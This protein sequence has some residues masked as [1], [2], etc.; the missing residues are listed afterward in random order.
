MKKNT[1]GILLGGVLGIV[2]VLGAIW[3]IRFLQTARTYSDAEQLISAGQYQE[4]L[5]DLKAIESNH[6]LDTEALIILCQAHLKYEDGEG[7]SAYTALKNTIFQHQSQEQMAEINA[8]M[9]ILKAEYDTYQQEQAQ[10]EIQQ[11]EDKIRNGVPFVGMPE[12]RI[13][14][15]SLGKPSDEV[16]HNYQV[17]NGNQYL[18]NLYDFYRD[19]QCIFT[20]RCVQGVVTQV[21][22]NR[23]RPAVS[24][25]P[26]GNSGVSTEPSVEGFYS[27]EDFYDWY[28]DDFFDYYDAEDYYYAH[29]GM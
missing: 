18:A 8:F 7:V 26:S 27:P 24:H 19:G 13:S 20:A 5:D 3:M 1:K 25:A 12:R 15:T 23:D 29:G 4:A 10:A 9:N 2:L 14:D 17:K 16:R 22:D 6:Y 21:W 28:W 11:Y